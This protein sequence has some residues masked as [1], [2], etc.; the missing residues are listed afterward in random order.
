MEFQADLKLTLGTVECGS[1]VH[2]MTHRISVDA[3]RDL[4]KKNKF[5][6]SSKNH[7]REERLISYAESEKDFGFD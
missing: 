6:S 7:I 1:P 2:P 5:Q 4:L 3:K